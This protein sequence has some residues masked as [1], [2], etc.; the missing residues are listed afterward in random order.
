MF[1]EFT[2]PDRTGDRRMTVNAANVTRLEPN[3]DRQ[4]M[5]YLVGT[6]HVVSLGLPY[7]DVLAKLRDA[8]L[9]DEAMETKAEPKKPALPRARGL[10]ER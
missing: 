10:G 1:I 7:E 4:T 5:L 2:W 6:P 9:A 8:E 3:G